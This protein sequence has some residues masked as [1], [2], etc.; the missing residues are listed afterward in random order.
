MAN[1]QLG[2]GAALGGLGALILGTAAGRSLAATAAKLGGLALIGGLAYKAQQNYQQG[3]PVPGA[4]PPVQP[5][6]LLLAPP[7]S[8]FEPSALSNQRASLLIRTMIAAAAADGRIDASERQKILEA[9]RQMA[10]SLE[11][12]RFLIEAVQRPASP[13]D[14]ASEVSSP[15]QATEVYTAARIAVDVDSEE[16]H[17][18][19]AALADR[20]GIDAEL[21]SHIDAVALGR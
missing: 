8:G 10:P 12:R 15:E 3:R 4:A 7:G 11:A 6:T 9:L 17:A 2:A 16:D 21:A 14:L 18:F 20:L 13:A 1:N 5:P 19:L